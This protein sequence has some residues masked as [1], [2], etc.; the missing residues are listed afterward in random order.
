[1]SLF[2]SSLAAEQ[3]GTELMPLYRLGILEGSVLS[4]ITGYLVLKFAL[5]HRH[6]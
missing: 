2:I 6:E 4:A 1:M 3:A 5:R